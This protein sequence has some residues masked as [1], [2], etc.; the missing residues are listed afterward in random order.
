MQVGQSRFWGEDEL[1]IG[2]ACLA[3]AWAVGVD[4]H[5]FGDGIDAG[6]Q[7]MIVAFYFNDN[8]CGR[9]RSR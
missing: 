7:Q 1:Q 6:W 9:R 5:A 4:D 8:T 3:N 2:A